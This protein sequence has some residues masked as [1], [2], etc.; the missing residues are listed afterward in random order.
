MVAAPE[1]GRVNEYEEFTGQTQACCYVELRARATGYLKALHFQDGAEVHKGQLLFEI[2][3]ETYQ[4]AFDQ[5]EANL[6]NAEAQVLLQEAN[7]KYAEAVYRRNERLVGT[8]A[9]AR[10]DL[11]QSQAA[12]DTAQASV[13]AANAAV[14]VAK[15]NLKTARINLDYTRVTAPFSGRI[16]RRLVDP[17]SD[18][19]ADMTPLTTIVDLNTIYV[20]FDINERTFLRIGRLIQQGKIPSADKNRAKVELGLAD[21]TGYSLKGTIDFEDN[22][23]DVSTGTYRVRAVVDNKNRFLSPG[24]FVRVRLPIGLPHDAVLVSDQAV[25]SDQGQRYVYVV[26]DK[27][28]PKTKKGVPTVEYR[29]VQVGR[30]HEGG[31][32]EITQGLGPTAEARKKEPVIVRG[33]QRIRPNTEVEP[34]VI[35]MPRME[36]K[37]AGAL[38]PSKPGK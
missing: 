35:A 20:Y 3:P 14:K 17:G 30:L 18:V 24:M 13:N 7:L 23:L 5:A 15:A 22:Q 6:R 38:K 10:Q 27:V 11:E 31:L 16:S 9:S 19:Q 28:D 12:R 29:A 36:P 8:G 37:P 33:I 26:K 25:G 32:R 4:A 34:R 21:E 1:E 2:D